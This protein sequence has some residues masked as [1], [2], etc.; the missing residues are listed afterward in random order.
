MNR[1]E[2]PAHQIDA[3]ERICFPVHLHLTVEELGPGMTEAIDTLFDVPDHEDIVTPDRLDDAV[4][5]TGCVL[6]LIDIYLCNLTDIEIDHLRL[7]KQRQRHM[8]EIVE[9]DDTVPRLQNRIL[10]VGLEHQHKQ[11][12]NHRHHGL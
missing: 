12:T 8:L 7:L 6:I 10:A 1:A 2:I 5:N 3:S 4:L 11:G 9:V